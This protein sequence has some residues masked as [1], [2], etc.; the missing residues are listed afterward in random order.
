MSAAAAR[1][2]AEDQIGYWQRSGVT[3]TEAYGALLGHS[4]WCADWW[5]VHAF[6]IRWL[7]S[8]GAERMMWIGQR[9]FDHLWDW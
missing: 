1:A 8:Q 5:E 2:I 6:M 7:L 3:A 9:E 4:V